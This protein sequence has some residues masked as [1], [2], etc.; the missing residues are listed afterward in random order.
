MCALGVG[1]AGRGRERDLLFLRP[2]AGHDLRANIPE[3]SS[4][5]VWNDCFSFPQA[6]L[7]S[8]AVTK[9]SRSNVKAITA[10]QGEP[11]LQL[12]E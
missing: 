1:E 3:S 10:S 5:R 2:K 12:E 6:A 11:K 8:E 4:G 9:D 7:I